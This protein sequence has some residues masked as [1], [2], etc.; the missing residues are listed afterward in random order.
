MAE[1]AACGGRKVV[2]R[3]QQRETLLRDAGAYWHAPS[4]G[5]GG[6]R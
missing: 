1:V 2:A 3:L 6:L 4:A 5:S